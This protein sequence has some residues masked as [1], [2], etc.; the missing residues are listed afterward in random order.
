MERITS[1]CEQCGR[2]GREAI[3]ACPER[4]LGRCAYTEEWR[5]RK[6]STLLGAVLFLLMPAWLFT[7]I[8]FV[9]PSSLGVTLGFGGMFVIFLGGAL[10]LFAFR[11]ETVGLYHEESGIRL[12][13]TTLW[14]RELDHAWYSPV[15]LVPVNLKL[16]EPFVHPP[17]FSALPARLRKVSRHQAVA[18][19]RRTL[20]AMLAQG[21]IEGRHW[22]IHKFK[23][24]G[25]TESV[26]DIY[27]LAG[28]QQL[29]EDQLKGR[30][31]REISQ[32]L[33]DRPQSEGLRIYSLVHALYG[34][35]RDNPKTWL[36]KLVAD[37]AEAQGLGH[38]RRG[39][40]ELDAAH[41]NQIQHE[42]EMLAWLS[43]QF[44]HSHRS[45]ASVL[46]YEIAA[47]IASRKADRGC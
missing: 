28:T 35:D 39:G 6:V 22:Q 15:E 41:I 11:A 8:I 3:F 33:R 24:R 45:F 44:A 38:R 27:T 29:G 5:K 19:V 40:F 20:I 18:I 47:G 12:E 14:G 10:L 4:P 21:Y 1:R 31:E 34:K 30:L 2:E 46:D 43:E 32:I 7:S 16:R 26:H 23:G 17:S 13:R 37:D 36:A 42:R 9:K 25:R